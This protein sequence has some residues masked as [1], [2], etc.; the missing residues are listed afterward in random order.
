MLDFFRGHY[1]WRKLLNLLD[2]LRLADRSLYVQAQMDDPELAEFLATQ[3]DGPPGGPALSEWTPEVAA[4]T[5]ILDRLGEVVSAVIA[6][7]GGKPGKLKPSPRPRT[8][9]DRGRAAARKAR[10][11][12]LVAEVMAAQE[13]YAANHPEGVT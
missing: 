10:H 7:A 5:A 2:N 1:S 9:I 13:R 4:L 11:E 6:A 8:A 12:S 3:P